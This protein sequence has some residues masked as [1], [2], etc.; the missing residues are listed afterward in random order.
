MNVDVDVGE[1]GALVLLGAGEGRELF[2]WIIRVSRGAGQ[3][4]KGHESTLRALFFSCLLLS[5]F[6]VFFPFLSFF[7]LSCHQGK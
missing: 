6:S 7:R 5:F 2:P 3:A 4:K 1:D